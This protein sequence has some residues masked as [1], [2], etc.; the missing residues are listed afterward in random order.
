M[1]RLSGTSGAVEVSFSF[2]E[3][4][5]EHTPITTTRPEAVFTWPTLSWKGAFSKYDTP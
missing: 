1:G 5:L 4:R 3:S 2:K